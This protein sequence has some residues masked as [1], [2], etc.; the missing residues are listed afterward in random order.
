MA[1]P[2]SGQI[3]LGALADNKSSASRAD[4]AMKAYSELFASGS[5][6]GDVDDSGTADNDDGDG[7]VVL[8]GDL[9]NK[10]SNWEITDTQIRSMPDGGLGSNYE[11]YE[12]GLILTSNRT[13]ASI[14]TS[15]FVSGLKGF[16][17]SSLGNGSAEFENMRIR[18]T[19]RTTVFEKESVNV[20]GGQLMVANSTTIQALKSG[21]VIL[22]GKAGVTSTDVTMS[23]ANASGFARGEIL[24]AKAVDDAGFSVEYL[25]VTGSKRYSE[26]PTLAYLTASLH[27]SGSVTSSTDAPPIDPDGIAGEIYVGR[28][29]GGVGPSQVS[30][31]ITRVGSAF[32]TPSASIGLPLSSSGE[33]QLGAYDLS[34][35][36]I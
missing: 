14:Q 27:V 2:S 24:K 21:S 9:G 33:V 28:G 36:H 7:Q 16:R 32:G 31:S 25:Y 26:D 5:A 23:V 1:L 35:I 10:I 29:Y 30:S 3:S 12:T 19:L 15:D 20:V 11:E 34:L 18:G 13:T 8:L 22:A 4:V 17:M 6:V